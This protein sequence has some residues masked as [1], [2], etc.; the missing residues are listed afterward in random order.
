MKRY[1]T[2]KGHVGFKHAK[3]GTVFEFF[4]L[5]DMMMRAVVHFD[6]VR[7]GG[8]TKQVAKR[9]GLCRRFRGRVRQPYATVQ[10]DALAMLD[11]YRGVCDS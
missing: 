1:P 11:Y 8:K 6:T 7:D 3:D 9:P 10:M 5:E 4:L 2:S